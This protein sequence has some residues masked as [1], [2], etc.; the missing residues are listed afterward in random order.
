MSFL[1]VAVCTS[2]QRY[3]CSATAATETA[4]RELVVGESAGCGDD[5]TNTSLVLERYFLLDLQGPFLGNATDATVQQ[6]L[7][8]SFKEA[9]NTLLGVN[10]SCSLE[11]A[12]MLSNA[13]DSYGADDSAIITSEVEQEFT[14]LLRAKGVC[15]S[16][17]CNLL[18]SSSSNAGRNLRSG[19]GLRKAVEEQAPGCPCEVPSKS[20]FLNRYQEAYEETNMAVNNSDEPPLKYQIKQVTELAHSMEECNPATTFTTSVLLAFQATEE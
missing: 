14:F 6:A 20:A 9:Y 15:N 13:F 11:S 19:D 1:F 16:E 17:S 7:E 4:G 18:F 12:T 5:G 8:T 3:G 2:D 10:R